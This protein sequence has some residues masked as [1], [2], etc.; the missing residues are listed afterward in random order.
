LLDGL[1][2]FVEP[3]RIYYRWRPQL[4]DAG[5]EIVLEA[6]LNG[7][8]HTIVTHNIKHFRLVEAKFG[9]KVRSPAAFLQ[10]VRV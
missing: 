1:S 4:Q 5:D 9:I 7:Q 6:A 3:A 2:A 10:E 8:A